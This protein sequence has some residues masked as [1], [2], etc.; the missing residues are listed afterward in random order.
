MIR[1]AF[2]DLNRVR[3]IASIAAKHGFADMLERSG[4]WRIVGAGRKETSELTSAARRESTAKRFRSLLQDLGPTYIKLGQILSTRGD[5]LPAEYIEELSGLQDD[6]A[7]IP[8]EHV[9]QQIRSSLGKEPLEL[10]RSIDPKPMAAAS[11]AQ[12]HRGVTF[13]GDLVVI[14]VQRPNIAEQ[15]KSDLSVLRYLARLLEAVVEETGVYT[16]LGMVDEFE[17][18]IFEELDFHHEATNVE[19]FFRNHQGRTYIKVPKVYRSL[20]SHSV[21][22]LEYISGEKLNPGSMTMPQREL[23]AHN[24]IEASFRQLFEDGLFHG[25]PHPGNILILEGQSIALLDF[26]L[27]G[28]V[29]R[30]MQETLVMMILAITLKDADSL[31]R[32]IY[33]VG[34]PDARASLVDFRQDIEVVLGRFSRGKETTLESVDA[35]NVLHAL[36]DLALKYKIRIPKEFAI[37][38]RAAI[39][40]EGILRN[41]YPELNITEV[42]LP[43]AKKLLAGRYD[44]SQWQGGLMRTLLRFQGLASD[45]PNQLSQILLDLEAGKLSVVVKS[46]PIEDLS[47]SV[48]TLAMVCF[49]GLCACGLIVGASIAFA[50]HPWTLH[51]IPVIG[52]ISLSAAFALFGTV[53]VWYLFGERVQKI[54]V[55]KVLKRL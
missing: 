2:Q 1:E 48:R 32:I 26:G 54:R 25:D 13:E 50:S 23:L 42:A 5:L 43:Y 30:S 29:S 4:V 20:S 14:K 49:L 27:V 22:T 51:G 9:Y 7:P 21:L 24:V 31:A 47:R 19:D 10:F 17:R 40:I 36:L 53:V 11:I 44:P 3:Q 35:K 38:S 41:L 34:V 18:A 37:L 33:R 39:A 16:P 6:A 15:I 45:L 28:R 46:K 8:V 52:L 12:V 55:S